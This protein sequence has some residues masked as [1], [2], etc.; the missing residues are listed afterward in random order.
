MYFFYVRHGQPIY[1]PDSLTEHGKKQAE[2]LSE[3][4]AYCGLDRIYSSSST[5]AVMTAQPTAD[6]LGLEIHQLP[7]AHEDIVWREFAFTMSNGVYT[8]CF[9]DK[10]MLEQF[11]KPEIRNL[12]DNWLDHPLFNNG[13]GKYR[14]G[15]ERI[16]KAS[17]A[18]FEELGF[19][20]DREN[21]RFI[22]KEKKYEKV[23]FFAHA[24]FSMEFLS[25]I[26]DIPYPLYCTRYE[27]PTHSGVTVIYFPDDG[28]YCVPKVLEYS[29]DS[30]LYKAGLE[31]FHYKEKF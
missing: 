7:F 6:K 21:H 11:N 22:V 16:R 18:F 24:G 30:H 4:F 23:A 5:R 26:L 12:G 20:K 25:D 31:P 2:A 27:N 10:E 1:S 14:E 15:F 29:N 9:Y 13:K 17:D 19:I 28:Q 3:R 8:W